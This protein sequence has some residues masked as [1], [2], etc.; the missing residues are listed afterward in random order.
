MAKRTSGGQNSRWA[1]DGPGEATSAIDTE[2]EQLIQ[3]GLERLLRLGGRLRPPGLRQ[4]LHLSRL[5]PPARVAGTND[6]NRS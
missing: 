1:T 4:R 2:T 5:T 6:G 3:R